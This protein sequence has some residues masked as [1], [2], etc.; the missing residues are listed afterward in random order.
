[1]GQDL[2]V[3]HK[4]VSFERLQKLPHEFAILKFDAAKGREIGERSNQTLP[5]RAILELRLE[6]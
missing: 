2:A 6:E 3:E 4:T 1:M 5:H